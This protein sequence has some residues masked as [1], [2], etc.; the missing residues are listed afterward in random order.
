[1]FSMTL[2]WDSSSM[3]IN[4]RFGLIRVYWNSWF[5]LLTN[6][7]LSLFDL[8]IAVLP[9]SVLDILSTPCPRPFLRLSAVFFFFLTMILF[10][11]F[12]TVFQSLCLNSSFTPVINNSFNQLFQHLLVCVFDHTYHHYFEFFIWN[13]V[14]HSHLTAIIRRLG[15]LYFGEV[16]LS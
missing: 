1:M 7:L 5:Y 3:P 16:T 11:A 4:H 6:L 10:P 15:M 14:A 13:F 12:Q 8:I 9:P 2:E